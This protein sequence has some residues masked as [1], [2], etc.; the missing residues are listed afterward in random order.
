MTPIK[1][2]LDALKDSHRVIDTWSI[3]EF[4]LQRQMGRLLEMRAG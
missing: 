1:M 4:H 2:T 3:T